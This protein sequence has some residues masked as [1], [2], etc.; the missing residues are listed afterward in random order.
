M[1]KVR[2]GLCTLTAVLVLAGC[3]T[4]TPGVPE[5]GDEP[6]LTSA[7]LGEPTTID[8]CSLTGAA[9]FAAVGDA[10]MPGMPGLDDCR[11]TVAVAGGHAY[12]RV[13][14]LRDGD[15]T[16]DWRDRLASPGR[17]T[18]IGRLDDTCD[19]VLVLAD[20]VSVTAAAEPMPGSRPS[21]DTLCRLTE[22]ALGGAYAV[23][24][25]GGVR[26]WAPPVSSLAVV[27]ACDAVADR[28]IAAALGLAGIA[29][30][31][32]P[33]EHRCRWGDPDG[34]PPTVEVRFLVGV[35]PSAVGVP[36]GAGS[37]RLAGR[38]SWVVPGSDPE[39]ATC[40]V[41]TEHGDFGLGTGTREYAVLETATG[42]A[43]RGEDPCAAART[44][45]VKAWANLPPL[46]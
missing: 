15:L 44:L 31:P 10:R 45:A 37:E 6:P 14:L 40:R 39:M 30:S 9:A 42:I 1:G 18:T 25:A 11:V 12:V 29:E 43:R 19:A 13:G 4:G 8:P 20:G 34:D 23:L 2:V 46:A 38:S 22:A 17:G 32:Y 41:V 21:A 3:T 35:S 7:A 36:G 27:H 16:P 33:A 5:A 26:H 24:T 28:D